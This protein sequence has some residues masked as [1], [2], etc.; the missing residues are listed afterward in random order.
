MSNFFYGARSKP[1]KLKVSSTGG[2]LVKRKVKLKVSS[3]GQIFA[4]TQSLQYRCS[5]KCSVKKT[6]SYSIVRD[7]WESPKKRTSTSNF[8]FIQILLRKFL[9][10]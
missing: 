6:L 1:K 7:K 8:F 3:T 10:L 4:Q 9:E 5:V 2:N